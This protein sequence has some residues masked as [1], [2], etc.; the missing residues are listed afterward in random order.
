MA[1][2]NAANIAQMRQ[3]LGQQAQAS[4][5]IATLEKGKDGK[6]DVTEQVI[7]ALHKPILDKVTDEL[8]PV[9]IKT[10][11]DGLEAESK[12]VEKH[13]QDELNVMGK[14]IASDSKK[15]NK[16]FDQLSSDLT[17]LA[18]QVRP[19]EVRTEKSTYAMEGVQ[20]A[21]FELLLS[22]VAARLPVFMVGPAGTGKT[23]GAEHV[24]K[25]LGLEFYAISV[26]SQTSKSDI[27]GYKDA[28]GVYH[29]TAF[30]LAY[31]KGGIFLLDEADAG[32]A[33][34][35]V[36]LNAALSN[37]YVFFPDGKMTKMHNDFRMIA[38]A[39]TYGNGAS[40]QYVGRNQLDAA[41]LD[42]FTVLTWD[43]DDR[44]EEALAGFSPTYGDRW[45]RVVR[46]VRDEAINKLDLR[47]VVSPRATMRGALLLESGVSYEET[48]EVALIANLPEA[49][50]PVLLNIANAT[51]AKG[52]PK[53]KKDKAPVKVAVDL[54][55]LVSEYNGEEENNE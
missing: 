19:I 33:N 49:E 14:Q 8:K 22:I 36:G 37:G 45:L 40:R 47:A 26:G 35:L 1:T 34:V 30:R 2:S 7:D 5:P 21:K 17:A 43:I 50:R 23:A 20:H 39:N 27:F 10:I 18:T 32:N 24:A 54:D 44:I 15:L 28:Q 41:T 4:A 31:E 12:V 25:A 52:A 13:I 3:M 29:P 46:A 16:N 42:R 9:L 6:I 11:A 51:W 55:K 53:V 38:T 48:V